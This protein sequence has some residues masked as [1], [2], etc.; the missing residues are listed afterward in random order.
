MRGYSLTRRSTCEDEEKKTRA[1]AQLE[2][3]GNEGAI[4]P[5]FLIHRTIS[6]TLA[7]PT[8]LAYINFNNLFG[9]LQ[10]EGNK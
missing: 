9:L 8:L 4:A 10:N 7:I 3:V 6:G 2:M 1:N 5:S